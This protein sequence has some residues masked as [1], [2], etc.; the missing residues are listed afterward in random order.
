MH[1]EQAPTLEQIRQRE[2][3]GARGNLHFGPYQVGNTA[4]KNAVNR[5]RN[6]ENI[7]SCAKQLA[8]ISRG[9]VKKMQFVLQGGKSETEKFLNNLETHEKDLLAV[10]TWKDYIAD[11]LWSAEKPRTP[12]VD[13][14]ELMD[15]YSPEVAEKWQKL[16][17]Q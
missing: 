1:G 3:T 13:A 9:K 16:T 10:P 5:R 8:D 4:A 2:Y 15:F 12:Y 14:I 7:L 6:L 17:L 11:T